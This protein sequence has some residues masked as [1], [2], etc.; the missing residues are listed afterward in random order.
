MRKTGPNTEKKKHNKK[1]NQANPTH[2][3]KHTCV[4]AYRHTCTVMHK[5]WTS[6]YEKWQPQKEAFSVLA[7]LPPC[8]C[9]H[10]QEVVR[11]TETRLPRAEF[12][13]VCLPFC[14]DG[15]YCASY[16]LLA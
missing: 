3:H 6:S 16:S 11:R 10:M 9:H 12:G 15:R 4:H 2:R 1:Q 5:Q 8:T 13:T 14:P 7:F